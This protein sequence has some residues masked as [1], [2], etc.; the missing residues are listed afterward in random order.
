[1]HLAHTV[2]SPMTLRINRSLLQPG[3]HVLLGLSGGPD[4]L[5]LAH[6]L[7][8]HRAELGIEV[9]ALHVHHGMRG[10]QADQDAKTLRQWCAAEKLSFRIAS[11]DVPALAKQRSI[12]V[13]EAGREARYSAFAETAA[14]LGANKVATA[15]NAEDQV[16]TILFR[17]LRGTGADGLAGIPERRPLSPAPNTPEVIRPLLSVTRAEIEAYVREHSLQPL[18]DS[19]NQDLRYQRSRIRMQL[20]PE[21]EEQWPNLRRNLLRLAEQAREEG[22]FL[23]ALASPLL[24]RARAEPDLRWPWSAQWQTPKTALPLRIDALRDAPPVLRR[25]ALL[26]AIRDDCGFAAEVDRAFLERVE[27]L[28]SEGGAVE[29]PGAAARLRAADGLLQWD[30]PAIEPAAAP[31]PIALPGVTVADEWRVRIVCE[32]AGPPSDPKLPPME[33]VLDQAALVGALQLRPPQRGDRFHPLNA[34]GSRLLSDL[35]GD[36]K[37]PA[38][39]R[40]GWPVFADGSGIVWV[41]GVALAHRVRVHPATSRCW[42]IRLLPSIGT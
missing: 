26:R 1:V 4:S 24:E 14:E 6:W 22:G 40:P 20:L 10:E 23:D 30:L 31:R 21:L 39:D 13:E 29:I 7:V 8:H 9:T 15:H 32:E 16:E 33:A 35:F 12:S 25:R 37:I 17:L 18:E 41:P 42:R 11:A 34:P 38:R 5:A 28:L 19:T 2:A 3:D 27:A 36:R